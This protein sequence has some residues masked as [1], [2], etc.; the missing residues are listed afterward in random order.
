RGV[1][2]GKPGTGINNHRVPDVRYWPKADMPLAPANVL[3]LRKADAAQGARI[4]R[5]VMSVAVFETFSHK[6]DYLDS[7]A[8]AIKFPFLLRLRI[9]FQR[10]RMTNET[11]WHL[12]APCC[13]SDTDPKGRHGSDRT[14]KRDYQRQFVPGLKDN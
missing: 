1:P 6:L 2:P 10:R 3:F 13:R 12:K 4:Q 8:P 9:M 5:G 14:Q 7:C 11:R